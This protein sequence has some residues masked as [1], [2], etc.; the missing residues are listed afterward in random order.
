MGGNVFKGNI[1]SDRIDR[2]DIKPTLKEFFRE[3]RRIFPGATVYMKNTKTLGSV[4]KVKSS[5]DIDLALDEKAIKNIKD[6]DLDEEHIQELFK[7]FKAKSRTASDNQLRRRAVIVAMSEK[8]NSESNII[9]TDTK[10]SGNGTLF[11]QFPQFTEDG[12]ENG[13]YIQIDLNIGNLPLLLF[14]YYSDAYPEGS[15]VKGL[16]RTQLILTLFANKG[17]TFSH[18]MGVKDKETGKVLAN[19]PEDIIA[20]LNKIYGFDVD[21][22]TLNNYYKLQDFLRE[23]LDKE[24]L[25]NIYARYL[26][27]L[28]ST[29]CDIPE[30]LED[31]WL[32]RQEELGLTGKFLP[33]SSKLYPFRDVD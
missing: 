33:P 30:D 26:K 21:Q 6:W 28:D 1:K 8:I 22:A 24:E 27:I 23:H 4:G 29:R 25:D 14:S 32:D 10:G 13:K 31:T 2:E 11:S 19:N 12:Q 9:V 18:N 15:K 17:L 20:L 3:F 16:H 5:G 7:K